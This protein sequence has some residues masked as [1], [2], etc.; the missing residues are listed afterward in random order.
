MSQSLTMLDVLVVVL[1]SDEQT[2]DRLRQ[3]GMLFL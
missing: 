3:T 2:S 1:E